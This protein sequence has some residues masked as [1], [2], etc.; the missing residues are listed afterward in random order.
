[1]SDSPGNTEARVVELSARLDSLV[2]AWEQ[3]IAAMRASAPP[4]TST[5]RRTAADVLK[6]LEDALRD[7]E[8]H[9]DEH[10]RVADTEARAAE[11][12]ERKAMMSIRDGRDDLARQALTQQMEHFTSAQTAASE[13]AAIETVRDAYRN[14]V[15]AVRSTVP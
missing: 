14:A 11:D 3:S 12:W 13:A 8:L 15:L 5:G 7:L 4:A 9:S 1:V 2:A 10:R 6:E